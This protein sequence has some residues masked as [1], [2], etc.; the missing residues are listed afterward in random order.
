MFNCHVNARP[1]AFVNSAPTLNDEVRPKVQVL[2]HLV[3]QTLMYER[4]GGVNTMT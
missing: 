3:F 4:D 2:N 1:A